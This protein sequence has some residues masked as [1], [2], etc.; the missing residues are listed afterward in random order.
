MGDGGP[1]P[2][3]E[4]PDSFT[5]IETENIVMTT[6]KIE[7]LNQCIKM[8]DLR[9]DS[10]SP[11]YQVLQEIDNEIDSQ[12]HPKIDGLPETLQSRPP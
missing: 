3:R 1:D 8:E 5:S 10:F 6:K 9:P 2:F 7:K 4:S 11:K 12:M